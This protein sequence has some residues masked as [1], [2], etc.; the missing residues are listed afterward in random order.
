MRQSWLTTNKA[1]RQYL[2]ISTFGLNA[3][4]GINFE[5]KWQINFAGPEC[6]M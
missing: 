2:P 5:K 1:M 6:Q 4:N 3:R